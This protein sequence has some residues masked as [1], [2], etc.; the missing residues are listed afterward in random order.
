MPLSSNGYLMADN[1]D[2]SSKKT[3]WPRRLNYGLTPR[4]GTTRITVK[5]NIVGKPFQPAKQLNGRC[6]VPN[7]HSFSF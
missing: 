6:E 4:V 2:D 1:D 3:L 7:A 5:K